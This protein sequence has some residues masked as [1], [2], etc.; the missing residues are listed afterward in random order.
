MTSSSFPSPGGT[1]RLC[2][3]RT[4]SAAQEL[5]STMRGFAFALGVR[6]DHC[7]VEKKAPEK[8]FDDA[9][10]DKDAKK[11]RGSCCRWSRRSITIT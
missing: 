5:Q 9:A 10:D 8:G 1:G 7:Q 6:C 4:V 3:A 2:S 11:L